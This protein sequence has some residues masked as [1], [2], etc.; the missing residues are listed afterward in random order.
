MREYIKTHPDVKIPGVNAKKKTPA[1]K[2][3]AKVDPI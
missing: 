3:T 1:T 2:E